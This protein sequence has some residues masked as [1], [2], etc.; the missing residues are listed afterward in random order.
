MWI[1]FSGIDDLFI[2]A[3][4]LRAW[5]TGRLP[6]PPPPPAADET[7]AQ[8]RIA[9]FVPLWQEEG[10]IRGMLDHNL[11]AVKYENFDFFVGA[12]PNDPGTTRAI[13]SVAGR[14]SRVHLAL[15]PHDGPTSQADCLNW[16]YQRMLLHEREHGVTVDLV[17]THDAEDLIHPEELRLVNHYAARYDMIQVPVL[18]LPTPATECVHGIYCDD[19]AEFHTKDLPARWWLGGFIPSSGVAT[20]FSRKSIDAL[21][22]SDSNL[23]PDCLTEDYEMGY[24]LRRLGF[25]Q[26]FMPVSRGGADRQPVATREFSRA[27]FA[28]LAGDGLDGTR[29]SLSRAGHVTDG[30]RTG[31]MHTGS[32]A[33]ARVSSAIQAV[34]WET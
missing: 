33:T 30:A 17:M 18:P 5:P 8:R 25:T 3:A 34:S 23:R 14:S 26:S 16:V 21:A 12:Y 15:C 19:F 22:A 24:R 27:I 6:P 31:R 1:F 32:G 9:I 10:V 7:L 28:A 11:A 4:F 2:L 20:A 13:Q 29:A